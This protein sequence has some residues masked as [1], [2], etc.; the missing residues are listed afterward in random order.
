MIVCMLALSQFNGSTA[1]DQK[2][3][4]FAWLIISPIFSFSNACSGVHAEF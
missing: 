3:G 4:K 2:H 1:L